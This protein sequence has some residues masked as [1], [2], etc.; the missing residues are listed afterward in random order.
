[1]KSLHDKVA[2]VTGAAS[3]IGEAGA[4]R[5]A[6]EEKGITLF[7]LMDETIPDFGFTGLFYEFE[8]GGEQYRAF[9]DTN[10]QLV[11]LNENN[12]LFKSPPKTTSDDLKTEFKEIAKEI[13][14]IVKS[15]S[16]RMEQ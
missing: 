15:Q 7:E 9:I 6:A 10:F 1:M 16:N 5:M 11:F 2:A 8:A 13:R 4:L 12:R 3:G 14:D